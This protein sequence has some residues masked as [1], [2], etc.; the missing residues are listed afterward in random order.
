MGLTSKVAETMPNSMTRNKRA[1][2]KMSC[3]DRLL[4]VAVTCA[5]LPGAL[6]VIG[7][8][9]AKISNAESTDINT[10]IGVFMTVAGFTSGLLVCICCGHSEDIRTW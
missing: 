9:V 1:T 2:E 4:A 5:I 7:C 8:V 3:V 10:I 6:V